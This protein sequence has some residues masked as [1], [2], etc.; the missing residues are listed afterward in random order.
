MIKEVKYFFF[1]IVIF[2]FIFFTSKY[3]FS[4]ENIRKSYRSVDN[5]NLKIDKYSSNLLILKNDTENIIEY[6][7]ENENKKKKKYFFWNLL[8]DEK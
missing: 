8:N 5:I 6:V 7:D 3:Y 1:T 4:D 2:V